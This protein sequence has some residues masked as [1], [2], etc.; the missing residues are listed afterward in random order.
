MQIIY[1]YKHKNNKGKS[2]T[3]TYIND[4]IYKYLLNKYNKMAL[5][6]KELAYELGVSV[7]SINNAIVKGKGIP[8]YVK[9][10]ND[11]K[12]SKVSF[13]L[14]AIANYMSNH[15]VKVA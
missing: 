6:K 8:A 4:E 14:L 7:S 13:S 3:S 5:N 1:H 9:A 2:M 11:S 12:N 15:T 10:N